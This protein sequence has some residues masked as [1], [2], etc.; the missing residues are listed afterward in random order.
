MMY[1]CIG[2]FKHLFTHVLVLNSNLNSLFCGIF[3][4]LL[5]CVVYCQATKEYSF[6]LRQSQQVIKG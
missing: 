3:Y 5:E 2:A 4:F 6:Y 1:M